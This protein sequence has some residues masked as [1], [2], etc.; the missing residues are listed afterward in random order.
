MKR[1]DFLKLAAVP[2]IPGI[3]K[4]PLPPEVTHVWEDAVFPDRFGSYLS[5]EE[6]VNGIVQRK[7]EM[8]SIAHEN[9]MEAFYVSWRTLAAEL[10]REY[11][12]SVMKMI[13]PLKVAVPQTDKVILFYARR[14]R[15]LILADVVRLTDENARQ[16]IQRHQVPMF[17]CIR[18]EL[19]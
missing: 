19:L 6:V 4:Y 17:V 14:E 15:L 12:D 2:F 8:D 16:R 3:H 9:D 10:W 5:E 7:W 13:D 11:D 18:K 1:R